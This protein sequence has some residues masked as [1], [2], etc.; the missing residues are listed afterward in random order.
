MQADLIARFCACRD[1]EHY[2]MECADSMMLKLE[3]DP[4]I[5]P[6]FATWTNDRNRLRCAHVRRAHTLQLPRATMSSFCSPLDLS[7]FPV[8]AIECNQEPGY[9][10]L[11]SGTC[12]I[13]RAR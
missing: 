13:K 6:K 5:E 3:H 4:Q 9:V 10:R 7:A 11:L 2:E 1:L 8:A 12:C